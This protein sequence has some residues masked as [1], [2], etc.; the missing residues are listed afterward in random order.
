MDIVLT[1]DMEQDC[2]PFLDTFKGGGTGNGQAA[3][4]ADPHRGSGHLF[5]PEWWRIHIPA[6][7]NRS[8][9]AAMKSDATAIPIPRLQDWTK[10]RPKKSLKPLLLF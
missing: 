9:T 6:W 7:W 4:P 2:P 10:L 8:K 5:F 1:V 3:G